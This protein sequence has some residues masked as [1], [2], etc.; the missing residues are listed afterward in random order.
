MSKD[1]IIP[2]VSFH[3]E[4]LSLDDIKSSLVS[5]EEVTVTPSEKFNVNNVETV[6]QEEVKTETPTVDVTPGADTATID[7]DTKVYQA[8]FDFIKEQ[9]L[10]VVPNDYEIADEESLSTLVNYNRQLVYE[11]ALA[12][13]KNRAGDDFVA[14][15]F[16]IVYNGGTID[17]V[18]F[19]KDIIESDIALEKLDLNDEHNVRILIKEYLSEGLDPRIPAH[20]R[21][22]DN[23]ESEIQVIF[24]RLESEEVAKEAKAHFTKKSKELKAAKAAELEAIKVAKE[25]S[26]RESYRRQQEWNQEFKD[27]LNRRQ[28]SQSKKDTIVKQFD[29]LQLT[30]GSE[31][32]LWKYKWNRMW[33]KPELVQE[34]MDFISDLDEYSLTFK[35]R[36]ETPASLATKK[37]LEVANA[38]SGNN[39]KGAYQQRSKD[40]S[41]KID[42]YKF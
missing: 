33:E 10:L 32:E 38:K 35:R 9:G 36:S 11:Q 14:E 1:L 31:V 28:W 13:V 6:A 34:F 17:D 40:Q 8:A 42:P 22:L 26:E 4:E 27:I 2:D 25:N 3:S 20:K 12:D 39:N 5:S 30:D 24:D 19:V 18:K 21:R 16:D 7:F 41:A 29:I 23:I 15:L 37:I